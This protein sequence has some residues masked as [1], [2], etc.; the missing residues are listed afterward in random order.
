MFKLDPYRQV[1]MS[2]I[3]TFFSVFQQNVHILDDDSSVSCKLLSSSEKNIRN[4]DFKSKS[5]YK[6]I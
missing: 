4:K 3:S 5:I 1:S 6:K 2:F